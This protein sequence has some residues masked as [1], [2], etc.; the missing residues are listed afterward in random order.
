MERRTESGYS[1]IEVLIALGLM[2]GVMV[3]VCSMFVLGG[4][5]VKS[6]KQLT[7]ATALAQNIMEDI[8][9]YSYTGAYLY[10]QGGSPDPNATS[11][12]S[13]TRVSGSVANTAWGSDIRSKLFGGYAVVDMSPIGGTATP[14]NFSTGEGIRVTI[15]LGWKEM[16]RNRTVKVENV[17]W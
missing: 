17:R 13:D 10:V 3:A 6:G 9:K 12:S 16:R 1:L 8:N 7:Q 4:T 15:T 2:S 5:Y 14:A 11:A